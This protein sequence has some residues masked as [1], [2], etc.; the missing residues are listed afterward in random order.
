[1]LDRR[2]RLFIFFVLA[3]ALTLGTYFLGSHLLPFI[4]GGILSFCIEPLVAPLERYLKLPR[5]VA[6]FLVVTVVAAVL[7]GLVLTI[8]A[9]VANEI[10]RLAGKLASFAQELGKQLGLL[11][12][13][14]QLFTLKF[15]PFLFEWWQ[16]EMSGIGQA[17][18]SG[19]LFLSREL[20]GFALSLPGKLIVLL[21]SFL[22]A[23][24]L[25]SG[26]PAYRQRVKQA[27]PENWR[28]LAESFSRSVLA[29]LAGFFRAQL[30]LTGIAA[31]VL[32][33]GFLI[34]GAP[35]ALAAALA[36]A[37]LSILPLVGTGIA[38]VPWAVWAAAAGNNLFAF[39]LLGLMAA[40]ALVRHLLE[41]KVLGG[42]VGLGP[43]AILVIIY[44]GYS[45]MGIKGV[46]LGLVLGVAYKAIMANGE[47]KKGAS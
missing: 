47:G 16:K 3:A 17:A 44:T 22:T 15:P 40:V 19:M 23:Y 33:A 1:M 5:K 34:T 37:P 9:L 46:L 26:L 2:Q 18:S 14:L 43:L 45:V 30:I 31:V 32:L 12:D 39:E 11:A 29:A 21:F 20:V 10:F 36:I 35:Y 6:S 7:V 38:L 4:L 8:P 42:E 27:L 28:E 41:P 13:R 25:S 24:F